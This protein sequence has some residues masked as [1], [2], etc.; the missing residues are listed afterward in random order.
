MGNSLGD[1]L[2]PLSL[3]EYDMKNGANFAEQNRIRKLAALGWDAEK[4]SKHILISETCVE[5]FMPHPDADSEVD[6]DE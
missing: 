3:S 2:R 1:V 5:G 6:E 4:I